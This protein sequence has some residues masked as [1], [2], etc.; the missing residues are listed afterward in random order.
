MIKTKIW[1]ISAI[2]VWFWSIG[3]AIYVIVNSWSVSIS[4]DYDPL[5][6][7]KTNYI[8]GNISGVPHS[9]TVWISANTKYID[10]R[11][12]RLLQKIEQVR[13]NKDIVIVWKKW[14]SKSC[15]THIVKIGNPSDKEK[16]V[17]KELANHSLSQ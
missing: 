1:I 15:K 17:Y 8:V 7:D 16:K 11:D 2:A 12:T 6:N 14:V 9:I 13:K 3:W 5:S 10:H 4:N